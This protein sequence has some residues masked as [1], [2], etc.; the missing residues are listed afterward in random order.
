[1]KKLV[2]L[3]VIISVFT[4]VWTLYDETTFVLAANNQAIPVGPVSVQLAED[5]S[6]ETQWVL[7]DQARNK[8]YALQHDEGNNWIFLLEESL[9]KGEEIKLA[10]KKKSS[11][12]RAQLK[13]EN[14]KINISINERPVISYQMEEVPAPEGSPSYYNRGGFIH[15]VYSPE[16]QILTDDFPEGHT[17]QHAMF[18]A[19]V[20]TQYR[21]EKVD[22][23]NQQQETGTIAHLEILDTLSGPVFA[24]IRC[25][26]AHLAKTSTPP[27]QVIT[28]TW[29]LKVY[30][31]EGIN[32]F[33]IE[34][35]HEPITDD[36]LHI[37]KYHYGGMAFRGSGQW[38]DP[39]YDAAKDSIS[40]APAGLVVLTSEGNAR[41]AAN[42][43]RPNWVDM[44]AEVDGVKAGLT[45][46][47][48]PENF[49]DPQ[50][51]RV[52]PAMPY[53]CFAPMVEGAFDLVKGDRYRSQYRI[54]THQGDINA[55]MM[56]KVAKNYRNPVSSLAEK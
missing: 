56:D 34:S 25:K 44:S 35:V 6:K 21:G 18:F 55:E 38:F 49:R 13:E 29:D 26:L 54:V 23:W 51:V 52:H 22:F 46:I 4:A 31:T 48:H 12:N 10:L 33:D 27:T 42:H 50:P 36:T 39:E 16:G 41:I 1:M 30:A 32:M 40:L 14:G 15:P 45:L 9:E 5:Y 19:W 7:Y 24:R 43:S 11:A 53:F 17:H 20:N 37:K 2:F 8:E 3:I 47:S 28:E